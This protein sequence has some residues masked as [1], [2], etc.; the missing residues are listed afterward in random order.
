MASGE[1]REL[2]QSALLQARS[3]DY[4]A[5]RAELEELTQRLPDF[6]D[7]Y[8]YLGLANARLGEAEAARAAFERCIALDPFHDDARVQLRELGGRPEGG[9]PEAQPIPPPQAEGPSVADLTAPLAGQFLNIKPAGFWIR[10]AAVVV[11][12]FLTFFAMEPFLFLGTIPFL[13]SR[14]EIVN[15]TPEEL[16]DQFLQ[17]STE[18]LVILLLVSL[19]RMTL[20]LTF[21]TAYYGYFHFVSG[22]TPGKR[23]MGVRVVEYQSLDYLT[24]SQSVWR[25]MAASLNWCIC[26]VGYLMAAFNP[27][28][29]GLHDY[30]ARTRVV[31]SEPVPITA[32]EGAVM[33]LVVIVAAGSLLLRFAGLL[34][35]HGN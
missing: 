12:G 29:R 13:S 33:G 8:F 15:L 6:A 14:P 11:D 17:G 35:G 2:L 30:M 27:E 20:M 32:G 22:Q 16:M 5:A 19:V 3:G 24:F 18:N 10:F 31:Y 25:Y 21:N 9:I 1:P 28:K 34:F 23:L 26:G 7:A 4:S